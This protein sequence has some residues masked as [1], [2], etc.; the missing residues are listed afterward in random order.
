[1]AWILAMKR[2]LSFQIILIGTLAILLVLFLAVMFREHPTWAFK[3][4]GVCNKYEVLK[5]LG[6]GMGGILFVLQV[7]ASHRRARA[8]EDAA[9]EQAK[10][11]RNTEQGQRQERLKNAIEHLG[12]K[13]DSVRL[14]GA[15]ELFH[16]A[17]DTPELCQTVLD[18]LCAHIRRTTGENDYRQTYKLKPSEEIQSVLTLLFVQQ[19]EVFKGCRIHL[20]GSWL[21]G[22]SLQSAHLEKA[23][24]IEAQLQGIC[25]YKAHLQGADLTE[26]KLQEATLACAHAQKVSLVQAHMQRADLANAHLQG[27]VLNDARLHGASLQGALLQETGLNG[28]YLQG[29]NLSVAKIQ[30]ASLGGAQMQGAILHMAELH[31][32]VLTDAQMQGVYLRRAQLHG[33]IFSSL[34]GSQHLNETVRKSINPQPAQ[35]H[36]VSSSVVK[37]ISGSTE[38]IRKRMD[39]ETDLSGV[40]FS[41]GLTKKGVDSLVKG[42]SERGARNLR[43]ILEPHI[44]RPVSYKLPDDSGAISGTYTEEEAEKWI[45][46]YEEAISQVPGDDS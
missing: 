15:Y 25:L 1:M 35:L 34:Q 46:E 16:L 14:G 29:A 24:L 9:N 4:L 39:K 43:K 12:H 7:L 40:I 22:A 2:L 18:I 26:A 41:G 38:R 37:G 27:S 13:S 33:A 8:M 42:L 3:L 5:F 28:T 17:E 44:D 19:Y 21:N 36:G 45:A 31:G 6:I 10:A 11:T 30:M 20:Q 32:A 23:V